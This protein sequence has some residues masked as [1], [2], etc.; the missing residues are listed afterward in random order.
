MAWF[1]RRPDR[2]AGLLFHSDQGSQGGF[3]RSMQ[4]LQ[5]GG[6]YGTTRRMDEA[7]DR[8]KRDAL[9]GGSLASARGRASVLGTDCNPNHE[10]EGSR[11]GWRIAAGGHALVP[12]SWRH[13]IV[14]VKPPVWTVSVIR[15]ARRNRSFAS[16]K[17]WGAG[18][19][20]SNWSKPINCFA[21]TDPQRCDAQRQARVP[22]VSRAVEVRTGGH[23]AQASQAGDEPA[24]APICPRPPGGQDLRC[25]RARGRRAGA[26]CV[27]RAQQASPW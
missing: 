7:I 6:V 14:H 24:S 13:A 18:N 21:R 3:N 20:S 25:P 5:P 15:R 27:H 4:H 11:G 16:P 9:C 1:R 22:G 23:K 19:S 17:R 2:Q 8:K 10:R 26:S 12:A